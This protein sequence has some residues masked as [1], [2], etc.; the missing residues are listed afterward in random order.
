[1]RNSFPSM[2]TS[3]SICPERVLNRRTGMG[4][5]GRRLIFRVRNRGKLA[6]LIVAVGIT[7]GILVTFVA[8]TV[9]LTS[10][11]AWFEA[12]CARRQSDGRSRLIFTLRPGYPLCPGDVRRQSAEYCD[13]ADLSHPRRHSSLCEYGHRIES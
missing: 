5:T 8:Q 4:V 13:R 2:G 11:Y 6:F 10:S 1:M 12:V 9:T 3:S 7:G